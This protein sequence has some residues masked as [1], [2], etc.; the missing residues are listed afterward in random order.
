[1][2]HHT[3]ATSRARLSE[4]TVTNLKAVAVGVG[5]VAALVYA[6]AFCYFVAT[7]QLEQALAMS[8]IVLAG[9]IAAVHKAKD[10]QESFGAWSFAT[11]ALSGFASFLIAANLMITNVY[12]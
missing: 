9:S 5:T 4:T 2:T 3:I 12:G 8:L 11:M 1:M 7:E 6:G 10:L